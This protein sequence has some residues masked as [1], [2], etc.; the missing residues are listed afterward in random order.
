MA[1]E[2]KLFG[3]L[4]KVTAD[5][6]QTRQRLLAAESRSQEPIAI[7]SASC[8]LPGGVDSPEALWQLVRT[9]TDAISEFPA[10]RGW[11]LERLYDPDP[12]HQGTSYTR[13]GGFLANAADFDPGM[14]GISPREALAM[15]PQQR[16]LLELSW[17]ALERA[18]ID[19][20]S[21][22]GSKTGV[23]G[24][25]TPQEYGPPLREMSRSA[26]GFGLTGRMVSVASGRVAY[27]FGFEGPAVTVDTAC[28]SSLVA[29]HLACQSLRSGEC[30]LALAGGVTVMATPATFVEFSRQRGLAPDGRCKSFAAAADGT[31]W[32]E[33]AGLV[34]LERL[35]DARQNGHEVLA[36]VRGSA[37]NQDGASNGLTAPNGPSQQRVITQALA[38]AG[39]SVSDVDAVEAHGTGT[40]LGDPIEA[41]ALIATYGQGRDKDRPL[42]LGSVKSNI[43]H[44]QAAA[45]VAGVIKMVLAMRH[46]QLPATLH[47][48]DPTSAVDWSAGSVRLLTENTP[49]P[50]SGR[51]CRVG[52]SSFGISGTNAHVILEQS[53]V[54]QGEPTGPV[55]G[56][57]EPEAAIPV[58]PWVVSGKTPEAARAQA[59]RVLSHV[60][61]RPE[62]SPADVA[63][64]LGV[65]RAA[66]D[67]RA[68]VLGSD[69]DTLLTGLRAFADGREVP[70]VVSGSAGNG[71]RVGFVF[72]GQGGQWLGMG[73]GL[74]SV[75]PVFADA[76]DEACTELDTHLGQEV[77]VRDVVFGSG[78]SLLD[79]T[80]WAQSGLFA[81][82][83]GLLRLLGSW[84]VRPDVVLGHS[85]GELA[86]AHAAGVLSLPEA[87]RLVAGRARLMQ[88]LPSGGAM[89]AVAASEAQVEPLLDGVR[90]RVEI[91]AINGPG[92]VVLSGDRELLADVAGRLHDQGCRTRWLRVSHAFHSPQMDPMLE[93]FAQIARSREYHA[94]ELPMISTLTGEL[95][96]GRVM[97]TPEYW[98]RQVREPV[99]FA[100]GVQALVGQGVDT[101]VEFG[102]DGALSTLVEE[103]VAESG[104]V[105][106]IPLMRKDRDETRTVLAALAQIH[107]RGGEV[108]WRSFFAGSGAKQVEL[109]T[110]AFQRQRYWLASTGG[111]GDVTAAGLAEADH[112]LLG[113]VVALA[114][115]EG[116]VLTGRL[117]AGSHPWLSD[118]RLLGEIVVPGTAIVELAWHVGERLGC[119]RVE[120]LA[121]ESPLILPDDGAVQVQV[122]VGPPGESG[123]RS[124]ALYSRP[125]DATESEW[126][127]H[128]TG[129][130]LPPV[131][132]E[133]HE[134]PAWPPDDATEIDADEVYEFL[135]GQGFAYGPAFRC[136]R[137]AWRRGGEV[138]AEVALPD[139]MQVG[140][141]F[142]VHPA[143][144][145]AVL[146]AAAAETSVVQSGARVPFSWRGVELRATETAVVRARI[147][148]TADDELSLVAVDP[149]GRFV[150]S[151]DSL[152]TRPI[153]R[154]QVSSGAIG[155]CLFEVEWHRRAL[156]DTT[157][158]DDLAI[159]GDGASWPESVRTTG[160]FATLDEL[161]SAVGSGVAVP[162]SVLVAAISAEEVEG[163][164]LPSRAEES[165]SELLAL[166]QLW[167][168]DEQLA[169]SRL[170]VVTRAAMPADSDADVADLVSASSWGLLR[171]AQSENPGRFVLVDVD[172]TPESWQALPTAVRAGEPQLAL[173]RGVALVPRL[174]RLKAHGE[175]SSPRLDTDGTVLITGGTGALGGVVARHLVEEH[176]I[177]RLV[178]AGRRGWNAP[179]VPELVDELA[180]SGAVVDVVACDVGNRRDLEQ[181]LAAIP[182]DCPLRG[183]VHAA[184][185]LADGVIGSLSAADVGTVFAPKVAGA[186]H[187]HELT[188]DLDLSFFVLFSSFSGIAG[189]AGQANYAAANTF[190]D[191]LAR[192]RRARGLP[193]VSLAWGL[194]TQR[195]GMTSA[196]DAA[197]VERLS[198]TGIAELSTEDGL[199]LFD[200]AIA[201][202]T[203]CVVPARLDRALLV[204][205]GRLNA[206]PALLTA[207]VP[208]RGG[209]ARGAANSQ[210]VDEDALLGLVRE[211]VSAVLGYSGAVEVGGDRAFRDLGFD[212]LSGVELRNR[213]AGVLGV[214][215]PATVVFDY[216]T[217]RGL[218]RFLHQELVGEIGTTSVP[219]TT[220]AAS[221]EEDLVAIVGM[222]CRFPGG[223]SSPEE[224]WRLVA[225]GV[226]A[227]AGFPDDRGWDLA[228]LFDPDPDRL[229]TSYVCEGGFLRDAA[230]FD[231]DMFGVSPREALAMDPQQ[232]LL[233]EIA[234]ETL[235]RA[236]ID[237]FSL[238]GSRT[239]VFAGL[240]Y[241]DYG[242]RFITKAPEG[243]EGHL[244]TGN[245]GS[246]LSGR[247]AYS[248][249]FEGPA[250]TVD[251]ACSSSLVALHLAGQ[252]LRA[253]ECDLALAGG[254]TV[255]ATPTTFVEFSRQRGLAPDGRC[256]SF[257]AAADGTGWG[258]GA[259]L[260]LLER[261]S[262]ARRN[263]HK[264]LAVVR[265]SA[266]NQDGASN[267]LT[268]PNGPSQQRVITQALT[269]AGLSV[270]DVDAVE[271]HGTGTRLGD[272][273]EAQALIATYG[274]DRDPGRPLWLGSVK[275]NIGH[276]QAAAGVAGVIKMVMAIRQGE[277]PRTL[278]LDEPSAQVD[279][280]AG[281]VQLLTEN[282]PWPDSG[283]VRR[284]GVSS[285]GI[286]GTNAH[287]ILEQPPRE[288]HRSTEPDSS[289]VRDVPV[290]PW[291]VSGKTPE[292]LSAQAAA[293]MSSLDKCVDVSP[294]DVGY[295]LAVTRSALDHRAVVLGADREALLS[296]LKALAA[297]HDA[298]E[299]LTGTRAAGPVGFV[300]S[301]QGGQW[302][303][304]GSGLYSAFPV[305]ADAFDEACGELDAHLGQK[306][307]V[308]D[309][310]LGSDTQLLDQTLW[311][312]SGLF[313][314][315]VGLW[316][317]LGSWGVRPG[318][319]LGHSVG[320][321][322][323]AFAAGVLPLPDA[324]RLVA[325]RARLMQALPPGGAMLAA[326]AGEKEL[327]P[328]LADCGDRV[329]IAAVNAP[330][331][332]VLSGDRDV[333]DDI[334]GRLDGQ[335][336]RS[337]WLRVSHAFH[338]HRMDPML[339]EF[340][341][342]ARSVD[343][344]SPGLPA[345]STLT[346]ELDEVGMMATPEYWVRQVREPV[347]FA[348]GVAALAA[349]GVS[350]IVEVGP[351]G[352]LSALVQECVAGSDQ[353]GRVAA[354]P[355]MRSNCDEA[356]KVMTALAQVHVR[357]AAVDWR[358]FFAGTGA[359]QVELP[360]YAF[361][362]QRYW[363]D[364]PSEPVGQSADFAPQ[365][366][367]WEL[368]EQEDVSALSAALNIT[369]DH[370]VQASLE[371]VVPALSSWHR[372][373]RN[374]SLVHQWRYRISWHE[375]A[376]LPDRSL[377]G[378]WLVVV[379]EGW[380]TSQQV[381][382]FRE[383]FE[384]RGCAAVL[385]E[386]A[387]HDEEALAQRFRTLPVGSRISGV[388]SLLALDESPSSPNAAL[389]NGALNSLVLLRALRTADVSA[390]LWLATCG[391]VAVGDVP[392]N[393]GQALVWGLG[394][395]VGLEHPDW[396]GGL[397]DVPGLLDEDA[398]ERLSV[399]LAGLG[400]DEIAV[401]PDG[402][403]VRRLGRADVPDVR[404]A[405]RPRGTVLVTG[406]TGGLG[407][408][409]ARWLAGAGAEHVVLTSRRGAEAPGAGDLQ[410]ELEALGARV[411]IRS[412]DVA[413]RDAL[414]EVLA[415]IPDDCPL[416]A[417]MHAAGVV[418]VGDVASMR[419][420]DFI[421]V[422]SAKVGG[423]A[424]LD[425]L[426][427]D[428]E[429][430]AFVLFS[431]V[432]GVWGA[433]GQGAYAAA[434]AYLDA[435]AQQRR[436]RGL[437][438]T[439][440]AWGPWAGDGMAAGEGGAQLR[441]TGLVPMPADR[442]LL[443]L[444]G[445]LDR[446]ETSLV[447][448]DMAWERFAPVFAVSRRRPLLDELP[449]AQQA[450][451]DA[452]N[453][454]GAADPAGPMQRLVGMA[455]AERRRAMMELV[456]AETSIVLGHN[457]SD[458]VSPDRAFQELGFDSLM[459]VELRNRL[460]EA[461]G[462]S[463]PATLIFDY[464]SPS[465][466]AAQLVGEL[467]GA[468]PGTTVVAGADPVD[469]PV[470]VVAMGCRYPGDVCSPEELWQLIATGRDAVS[471]FP[472]DRGWDC[473]ALFDPDPD[474]ADSTYVREGAFLTGADRFDAGFFGISPREARAMDPQQRLLLEV[475]W[476][477]F[478]RAGIPAMSL[479]GSR[480]GVF[481][482]TNG[483]DHGAKVAAAPEAAGH[484]LT[485]N[486]ASVMAGRLSYTFGLEGPAVAVDTACS[487]SLVA[488]HLACQS[489]RSGECDMA[490]A[491]GVTVMSTPLA[492]L[493]FSRQRGLA[494]DGRC[495]SFAAAADGTGWGEG[496]GLVLLERMSDARRNGHRVLA[497][498]RG[499]AVNQDGASNGLTAPNGPSQQR[500]IRQALA[501]AGLS[502]SDVDVVEAHGTGTGLGDPI[503][504]QALIAAY[505]QGRD[506]E[507]ALW[508]GSI[509]S[510][511]GH[512]QAAAGVAGV[513]K[514]VQAM[515]HGELPATLHV[516]KPTPQVDW[517]AG[518]VRLLTGNTPW[519]ETGRP[520]RAGVSS[521]GISGTNAH[522]ILEQPPSGPAETDRSNRRVT[523]QPA[524]IPW[525]LSAKS[526]TAL[527]AQAAALH[528]RLDGVPGA[529]PLDVGYSLATTR[530]ALDERAVVWGADR[531]T[532]VS[533]LA[534]LA[535]GRTA[536][537]VVTGSANAGGR[538]GFVFSGQGSQWLG[539]GKA[540]CAA[541]PAF[542]DAFEEA[543]DEL[544][545]HLGADV[546]GVLFGADEQLLDRTLW[547]QSGI[548]AV[549]VGLLGLLRSWGVRPDAVLG[550]SVGELAA[551]H[552][553]GVL[554]LP[555]AARLVAARARL[556][557][558]LPTGGAMLAVAN[559]EAAVEPV[560]AGMCDRVSIAS[561]NGPES[562][563]LSGDR[564]VLVELAGE[565]DARGI[566][567]KWLRVSHAFHSHRMEP[568]LD[569]Y[570]ETAGC[571][572]FGEPV[573]P[574]VS[575]ATGA[576]DTTGL[577]C[578]P[579]YWVRQVRDPVR[580]G[581]GVQALVA[582]RVDT[583]VEFG[584]DGALS[585]L[586]QECLA[587][588]DQAG[589]VAA[590]PLMR[591]DRDEVETA[592][593]AL[594]HVHV[595]GGAVD[596]SACF[597]GTSARTV[598]LPTYAFQRQRYW[599]AEQAD[600]C[601]GDAVADPVN[602]RFWELVERADP[603]PLADELCI[604][605]DQPFREV[606]PVL[607]S[608]RQKQRQKAVADSWRY[609][610]RWRSV[611]VPSAVGLRGVWLVVLPAGGPPRD[612][613]ATVIDAL[614][615][616]GAEVAILA[617][618]EQDFQRGALADKVR[619]VIADRTE[620]TG[621]LSL[622]AMDGMPCAEHPHLSRGAAATVILTQVLGD[623][624]V[625][626]PLWLGTTGGVEVG[627]ENSPVDPDH[628][629]I[630][631]L[632][633]VVGLEHP[634]RWG[635]LIDLPATLDETS[636]NGLVAALAG[637]AAEDQLAVRPSGLFVRRVVRAAQNP[638]SGTWRSRGTV[639]IT[640]GTGALGAEV[641]RW[642][643]RRGAEH[644][645]LISRRGP[646]APGA[647]DLQA[648]LTELGVKVTVAA[649]DVTDRDELGAVL[650]AVPTEHPLSA[651]VH[652][653]GVGTPANLA[654]TTLAQFADV[655]SAK[656]VGAANLDRLLG[657]QPLDAFVLFSSISGVWGAGGQGAYSAAN[658]YLD[659]LAERRRACG[660]PATCV[661]WG[662]WAGA[663]MAVQEGNEAHL[664]RRGLV[665]MEP[666]SALSALQQ[667]LSRR[668][669]A[670]A[671]ADVDWERFA[672][673]FTAARPRPLLDEIVDLRPSTETVAKHGA[674]EL[675]QQLA[676]LPPA[677]RGHLLLEVVL[678]ETASTLGH[679]S[680]EAVQPD[681]TFA[682]LGFDSLTAVELRNRLN[683]VTGLRLPPTLVFDHPTP[684]AL[685]E[686]LVPALVAE[687]GDGIE[688]LLAEL[689]RLD[690][691]LAQGPSIPPEDQAKVAERLRAL[692]AKWDGARDG[693]AKAT[694]PQS[695][696]SATDDEIFDLIDRKFRR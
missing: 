510:N 618:T 291:M 401:R 557:Q 373:I 12:D 160:R 423:A 422:L 49:W 531:E 298:A 689:D 342:I 361:Q 288:T 668:E 471:T 499:S 391:G 339:E 568:I 57:R 194:W 491:G 659:A 554:S 121:L 293:L 221:V 175:G 572:K 636:R 246:V 594:A 325:G 344:R 322:A 446:D 125:G 655:L 309:V 641:A 431:S 232:R 396:W 371:S 374:E 583:I 87:A 652:T 47:V 182:V 229:G 551:A 533:R 329:G 340:A 199:R 77:R 349:H 512:T 148:L 113:A 311:A 555:D 377:S 321:L 310:I 543:C 665:P 369:G 386:L 162:D 605:R 558:A 302:P 228:R 301:G 494:P 544:G 483:Q 161:R 633:R 679:D 484:L 613:P 275:S 236:G 409:V 398:Q 21:L 189:A 637:T 535:D 209:V 289:S 666:Q 536:P 486:A 649:C 457:G 427:A 563:V 669:T 588:S 287:L 155:D 51:P 514:M 611:E 279:W 32:G 595:R 15:D 547:A 596:W 10:D 366:D 624:G 263:G 265:G 45:G 367:F 639:L 274:R 181:A 358:S 508:L 520:R 327:R 448:A 177:R 562:V 647:A 498:I 58:V 537:G 90:D 128:A 96:G 667:A 285:F 185:V 489:L 653:A 264:V 420:T 578:A 449:E 91:A 131:A 4:K 642:L 266:V 657:G 538:I 41:Q 506:P 445:A 690:T 165:T 7:V 387:G 530:S 354:V 685:S 695:L 39:L 522:L 616:R 436:A 70:E 601:G 216:P 297:S 68:V 248:F 123:A 469:D 561:I 150:A 223:V 604:D 304:M 107:T 314:L 227:V 38:N 603:E 438:G 36:V 62:L 380:S 553:A 25:V 411:S 350:S 215:L 516:D 466:L 240:M 22:R 577:M 244:G 432:S 608:W 237:P 447:V 356:Q 654:E 104:Q 130:L 132:A 42:W 523:A 137:G 277:L 154:Q 651:V 305:F 179:G 296:G 250:V 231:A 671:V 146:H 197:S 403:F 503:E 157:A 268:A 99:R 142:G 204:E 455:A 550:H 284:A 576:L 59:E 678:A 27:S 256:K 187:L 225:G 615:A 233:L 170:V 575:A 632:G 467:V 278:H 245:A 546:R 622:L 597:A 470:V 173:R 439:A 222:G 320:E 3:Y 336:V 86:A 40:R 418:E 63:Y 429:L 220:R 316:E 552:A 359:K 542:A 8:R 103:C 183:I 267:G 573:V 94:P 584:P 688:S 79:R 487:S 363:L 619:A 134:L 318:V 203:A 352:V 64:S 152:V 463:L 124:M 72:A 370:D 135:E 571:V 532:L 656:V 517:S 249:G 684:L 397:V 73:R 88:A 404:S 208:A 69:R 406:G 497:V 167:L 35:S 450:L 119:G 472:T 247:V 193:G 365:S 1:S 140:D 660:R 93:E 111:A 210:A 493:E 539:M 282:T 151:V 212:S 217:P 407:A 559:S 29:L 133:N 34:L 312:Q 196:L 587:E 570:A 638:R 75:F 672:A 300:F 600:D 360:T 168:A 116:V 501:N 346:G 353:G 495:K 156:S 335:G 382:R 172:G 392:V 294:R 599:L 178:L 379:P 519:P 500:V 591:R 692:L 518:A 195:S 315:Q 400:E 242:A 462:L 206:V 627:T 402:V 149:T 413:D 211:H 376:A 556:M 81:L 481:A 586:V 114:D 224:L 136:L 372:R 458:A 56:E 120:E 219:V 534:A 444:Q 565:L 390:P 122:L 634:Q 408:H 190:L 65:T 385:F 545:A 37:V 529:S 674:G 629:L 108:D 620:V 201:T 11:D 270:S 393:P 66:L 118:H 330:E 176:G 362:R 405:W 48:D 474:R 46:G 16:L 661:A 332:V 513:I 456:L 341:E 143:L 625:S 97:G 44:T 260:V 612:Q 395:V 20:T 144:L 239:G 326:A 273:I 2:E 117:T 83:V 202:D 490:L 388:L 153:S 511:I 630:W 164:S 106:G 384:E 76:F 560:L 526:R 317:L 635:G 424:N 60:E 646:E 235:E 419:L 593:A 98:V 14:F 303:G 675:G 188:R 394:R 192:Y 198:R 23:F 345:V 74:Y 5:L 527:Q 257:A 440:V 479:R 254:V 626:A 306:A 416:T 251:T 13:A 18:G 492:F 255:M 6:H 425:E 272:P 691:T 664:R 428:V 280:S 253:G 610:V 109:P 628:G 389:P 115:G 507:R 26:G 230:E 505:G 640:G 141:R 614:I 592:V 682:E 139:D 80:L 218:A 524:V 480:T 276:T 347:R 100:D 54:G 606:L 262:D 378:T 55:E 163:G 61:D 205:K 430:D 607:A 78:E 28:S 186:W 53:P 437:V 681:R 166:V 129:V 169:E 680:A 207:L 290:V 283:R 383:M 658:A 319:V 564:D 485:G 662:P 43:G 50:D 147:S 258:E 295:S 368:V 174:A 52:V 442:A 30:D 473:N 477:V 112:P 475:A 200:A 645:V 502:A 451:A 590:I 348:D 476:E 355:L 569:E 226:D 324:A 343:Y 515:R 337:R 84:G 281:T 191:A 19:P 213:L 31:G 617:L 158:G 582:Q 110:Y 602:A 67:E 17:E 234:W 159:V 566:R 214:R 252:A 465:A 138:F 357:G 399:V 631:G 82:Q 71:G 184:G 313:A 443:A 241:H 412:C 478:E 623:A 468:R 504:A 694:S 271:A 331:S 180:R 676:A 609:Q 673:S 648:E 461:T 24:G 145:D 585:A 85:V 621:V 9:G 441:R 509:K 452:E 525:M 643:A 663:G 540:L 307:R 33:G 579:D 171:S 686:Q 92:S 693:T 421:G 426:L 435:L 269:S 496:A 434:N 333:L 95:D 286:S 687:P 101:I 127:K 549:Q 417:V 464:P 308:R 598:E 292:A 410:A 323:A 460:G 328:L 338:S 650:A 243:F 548:F 580:F 334:A 670:I 453:T 574:I 364:S 488:M 299:V 105:A 696:T 644:L 259:G 351:D 414:A 89:L 381:Q 589:R 433:G 459:A 482:G 375:R 102:P 541:F 454:T 126:R 415:T 261:L 581:D 521:F 567:T 677:E 238:R 528:G 683:A